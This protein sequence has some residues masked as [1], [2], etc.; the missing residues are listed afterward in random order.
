MD[1]LIHS[2]EAVKAKT[3]QTELTFNKIDMLPTRL[4]D[5]ALTET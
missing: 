1:P 4:I 3:R 5:Q 2:P